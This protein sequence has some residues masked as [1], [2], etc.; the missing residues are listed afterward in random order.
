[1][2]YQNDSFTFTLFITHADGTNPSVTVNP[3]IQIVRL[4]GFTAM[5][6][7]PAAMLNLDSSK[8][9]W[10]YTWTVGTALSGEYVAIVSYAADGHTF[11]AFP[12]EKVRVG[13]SRVIGTVALDAT[14][15]KDATVAKDSTVAKATDLAGINPNTSAVVLAIKSKTDILPADP[16]SM[17]LL[18]V[19][20]SN[21]DDIHDATLGNMS[22]DKTVNPAVMT[23]KRLNNAV[24]SQYVLTEDGSETAKT[25][26]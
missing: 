20:I 9:V 13:D 18:G 14:V 26:I 2:I 7:S 5:L 1:M 25:K 24:L 10:S 11:S 12:I 23:V 22:I 21:V 16:V 8:Q 15:S 17:T 4:Q 3:V 6:G 19:T